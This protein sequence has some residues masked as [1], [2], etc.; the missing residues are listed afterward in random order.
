MIDLGV[1]SVRGDR[2]AVETTRWWPWW[3]RRRGQLVKWCAQA[4]VGALG[5]FVLAGAAPPVGPHLEQLWTVPDTGQS[6]LGSTPFTAD[7][8]RLYV[9]VPHRLAAYRLA[10]GQV[11]WEVPIGGFHW[12]RVQREAG[13]LLATMV[14]GR[15]DFQTSAHDP[16]TGDELWS[17]PGE[18]LVAD[19]GPLLL[20]QSPRGFGESG[21]EGP[22]AAGPTVVVVDPTTGK[23]TGSLRLPTEGDAY[24]VTWTAPDA[25]PYLFVL[26]RDGV[27]TRHDLDAGLASESVRTPATVDRAELNHGWNSLAMVEGLVVVGALDSRLTGAL[28]GYDPLTLAHRWTV[29][30]LRP[31]PCGPVICVV[32]EGEGGPRL[33]ALDPATGQARWSAGCAGPGPAGTDCG[34]HTATVLE[35]DDQL[36]VTAFWVYE[37]DDGS[38]ALHVSTRSWLVDAHTGEELSGVTDWALGAQTDAG[39][40]L[41]LD[42]QVNGEAPRVWWLRSDRE[43]GRRELLGKV[44]AQYCELHHPYLVCWRPDHDL[45][46]WR[47]GF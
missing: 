7:G 35:P 21:S 30:A 47:L 14:S 11:Q 33:Q 37:H 18:P 12:A 3:W 39:L 2:S 5:L 17:H 45:A 43:L 31:R 6:D 44:D 41:R 25:T 29:P 19:G 9:V 34:G 42:E 15:N 40:M 36:W 22:A 4:L 10:D 13:V 16:D 27:L 28:S 8:D 20:R 32:V 24:P 26:D 23:V 46:V 1:Y 38:G